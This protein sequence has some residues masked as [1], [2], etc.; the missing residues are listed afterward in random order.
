MR[1]TLEVVTGAEFIW[2]LIT[3]VIEVL[4]PTPVELE[5]GV[6]VE[7]VGETGTVVKRPAFGPTVLPFHGDGDSRTL[8]LLCK[9]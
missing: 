7:T 8:S 1:V 6:T 5:P 4:T 9:P 3:M 2:T